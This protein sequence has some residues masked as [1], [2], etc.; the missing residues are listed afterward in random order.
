MPNKRT[1]KFSEPTYVVKGP[2]CCNGYGYV[3]EV[4]GWDNQP[5]GRSACWCPIGKAWAAKAGLAA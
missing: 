4:D 3:L 5:Y 1:F 2:S